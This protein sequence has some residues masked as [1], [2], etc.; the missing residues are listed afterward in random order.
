MDLFEDVEK[1]KSIRK[2]VKNVPKRSEPT[3]NNNKK[4]IMARKR[5]TRFSG[6]FLSRNPEKPFRQLH[7]GGR[8]AND[9]QFGIIL[10]LFCFVAAA[11]PIL[12]SEETLNVGNKLMVSFFLSEQKNCNLRSVHQ[13]QKPN[14][15]FR[16]THSA[17]G[18]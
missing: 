15:E 11:G 2:G 13:L 17:Q 18:E 1:Q 14:R 4:A 9:S 10:Y 3:T 7:H 16:F 8:K 6:S 5:K 12:D